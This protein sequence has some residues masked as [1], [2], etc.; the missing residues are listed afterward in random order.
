MRFFKVKC[1]TLIIA[2][3]EG[4]NLMNISWPQILVICGVLIA[5]FLVLF[6][7]LPGS[8]TK[9]STAAE[10][11][12]SDIIYRND[13]RYWYGGIFY[14]NPDDPAMFVPRRFSFGWTV[15]FGNPRGR[16][17]MLVIILLVLLFGTVI[18]VLVN[19]TAPVGCHT[20]GCT[21]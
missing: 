10:R 15:N 19:S 20:L 11:P 3:L 9:A 13:D 8:R 1:L 16:L 21:P 5:V 6:V 12:D 2:L 17:F 7:P 4:V 14:Y 18:P